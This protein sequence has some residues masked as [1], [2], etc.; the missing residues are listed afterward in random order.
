MYLWRER[1][2]QWMHYYL[3]QSRV[4]IKHYSVA[5]FDQVTAFEAV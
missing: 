4:E 3:W 1:G 5:Q 2:V